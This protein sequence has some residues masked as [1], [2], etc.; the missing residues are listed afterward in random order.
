MT[1]L[2]VA[3]LIILA[4]V[5]VAVIGVL[6]ALA[7]VPGRIAQRRQHPQTDAIR[8]TG[9]FGILIAPLWVL[10]FIWAYTR[11]GTLEVASA[12]ADVNERITMLEQRLGVGDKLQAEKK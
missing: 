3:A 4:I 11:S 12:V 8:V 9:Y 7:V 10:A 5:V 6:V 2:D 1:A